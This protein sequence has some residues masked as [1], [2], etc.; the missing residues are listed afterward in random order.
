MLSVPV[1]PRP[2]SYFLQQA[3]SSLQQHGSC[4]QQ[5]FG[6]RIAR[7]GFIAIPQ[8]ALVPTALIGV[9]TAQDEPAP[10]RRTGNNWPR[11][12]TLPAD[13]CAPVLKNAH[14]W[15]ALSG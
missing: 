7:V 15:R 5:H 14:L 6:I 3:Q 4:W 1:L 8:F 9:T 10:N 11:P 13:W 2:N 12:R